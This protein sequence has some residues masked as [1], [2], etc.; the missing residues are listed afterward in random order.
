MIRQR[1]KYNM[2]V[3]DLKSKINNKNKMI[4]F[5]CIGTNKVI[6]DSLGP[7]VGTNLQKMLKD[8]KKIKVFGNINNPINA[9]NVKENIEYINK[10]YIDKYIIVID[11]AVSDKDLIGE[12]FITKNKTILGKGIDNKISEIGDISIK[13]SVSN[14]QD[15]GIK[16]FEALQ[17]VPKE[18]ISNLADIVSLGIYEVISNI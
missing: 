1:E 6:G 10:R 14:N 7:I 3:N 12:I 9:L 8:N 15:N 17:K 2:F 4:I 16:N 5:L 18:F 11:S 13:C